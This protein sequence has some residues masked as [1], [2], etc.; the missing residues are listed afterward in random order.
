ML[1][2]ISLGVW[3]TGVIWLF[4]HYFMQMESEFGIRKHWMEIVSL[5]IHGAFSFAAMWIFGSLWWIH[6]LRGW[7]ANWR[8]WS[9]GAMAACTI[10][11]IVTGWGLYYFVERHWRE[12][13][14]LVHWILG[15]AG[16]ALFLVH[17]LSKS[18]ARR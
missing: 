9:G 7:N 8:R 5:K 17:W 6:I 16:A 15:L 12:W 10:I 14:S 4:Y 2:G 18:P 1:F 3:G 13:T 11:L